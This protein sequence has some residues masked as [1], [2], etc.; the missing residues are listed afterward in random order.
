MEWKNV[1][2]EDTLKTRSII[3]PFLILRCVITRTFYNKCVLSNASAVKVGNA[4]KE[5]C[6]G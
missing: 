6:N 4:L 2:L 3:I 1:E 5:Y